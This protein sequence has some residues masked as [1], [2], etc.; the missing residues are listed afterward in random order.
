MQ[1]PNIVRL[2]KDGN[3][4]Y[5][6]IRAKEVSYTATYYNKEGAEIDK[7]ELTA[8]GSIGLTF[9][10]V[11]ETTGSNGKVKKEISHG[12]YIPANKLAGIYNMSGT[13]VYTD[14]AGTQYK[15][16]ANQYQYANNYDAQTL[17]LKVPDNYEDT[18]ITFKGVI[19]MGG[20]GSRYGKS[21]TSYS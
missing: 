8:G 16:K 18:A 21:Q 17:K 3:V 6:I 11:K 14:E 1:G 20:F 19:S 4:S 10:E 2:E 13:T 9:G 12:L 7:S 5:Q 15:S